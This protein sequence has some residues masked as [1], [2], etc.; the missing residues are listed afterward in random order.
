M[1]HQFVSKH[2]AHA[3]SMA[4]FFVGLAIISFTDTWWP[5][6]LL[7]VGLPL[8]IRQL[9]LGR[10]YDCFVTLIIFAGIFSAFS[11]SIRKDLLLPII[12]LVSAL[13]IVVREFSES[14]QHIE[15]EDEE[16][17]NHEIEEEQ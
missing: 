15:A 12:F 11:F 14:Y 13:F 9:L 2:R 1:I 5:G 10:L 4:L 16:D 3:L 8:A 7:G 17:L 6:I